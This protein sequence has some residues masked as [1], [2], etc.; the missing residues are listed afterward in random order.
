MHRYRVV[1]AWKIQ[2]F[3]WLEAAPTEAWQICGSGFQ[4]RT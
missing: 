3:S 2:I 1:I 4:P